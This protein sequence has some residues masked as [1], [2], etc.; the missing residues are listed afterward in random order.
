MKKE[1]RWLK[2]AILA[3]KTEV[4]VLPWAARRLGQTAPMQRPDAAL[5]LPVKF[6]TAI[7][8]R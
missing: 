4:V 3:A 2:S 7:A 5:R 8:A 6:G 1:R